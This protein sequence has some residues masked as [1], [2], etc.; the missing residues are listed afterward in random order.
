MVQMTPF[1]ACCGA[2]IMTGF[3]FPVVPTPVHGGPQYDPKTGKYIP[4]EI[5]TLTGEDEIIEY[6][7][8][9]FPRLKHDCRY[10]SMITA[11]ITEN[12]IKLSGGV[13]LRVLHR[14]G[15]KF[16]R[17]GYNSVHSSYNKGKGS[18]LFHFSKTSGYIDDQLQ[19]PDKWE[20]LSESDLVK[21]KPKTTQKIVRTKAGV[22]LAPGV[23][24]EIDP[25]RLNG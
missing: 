6:L 20:E 7:T 14:L 22:E 21:T 13:W 4:Q 25:F 11:I 23:L 18:L 19:P 24:G 8:T 10:N 15:F 12:Q 3:N 17:R 1:P 16:D 9:C 2:Q 5:K